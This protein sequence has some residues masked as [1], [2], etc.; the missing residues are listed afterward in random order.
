LAKAK[1]K[2]KF[3]ALIGEDVCGLTRAS[4]E[5]Q[6]DGFG[7]SIQAEV[8]GVGVSS[9]KPSVFCVDNRMLSE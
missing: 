7:I 3:T 2:A 1:A 4:T 6:V 5:A 8:D 9:A